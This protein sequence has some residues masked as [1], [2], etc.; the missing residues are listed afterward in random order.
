MTKTIR[1]RRIQGITDYKSRFALLKSQNPRLVVR[2]SN[3]YI[4]AQVVITNGAQ[5]KS[6]LKVSSKDLLSNGWP[7]E[8]QGSLKSL[9]AAYL[10]GLLLAK[11]YKGKTDKLILDLGMQRTVHGSRLFALLAGAV[12]G[13]LNIP[14]NPKVLPKEE[15]ILKSNK[16]KIDIEK[17]KEKI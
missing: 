4:L 11:K 1:R 6:I 14:H 12:K 16:A 8:N 10:T 5:D 3:K 13:G 7:K 9:G 17:I 2:K 15:R